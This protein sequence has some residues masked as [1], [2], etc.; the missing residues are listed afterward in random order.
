MMLTR[1][2]KLAKDFTT[3]P[4][5]QHENSEGSGGK[6]RLNFGFLSRKA[7]ELFLRNDMKYNSRY[8]LKTLAYRRSTF[9]ALLLLLPLSI[10]FSGCREGKSRQQPEDGRPLL[11]LSILPQ[12]YFAE[13]IGG[14][15]V[16][17]VVLAGPGQNPHNY[18]M[19]PRQM[20]EL[21][22][23]GAWILSGAEFEISLKPKIEKLFPDLKIVNSIEGI[24]LRSLE[25]GHVHAAHNHE[26]GEF[27]DTEIDRHTW[28]GC[29]GAI[30]IAWHIAETLCDLDSANAEVYLGNCGMLMEEIFNV[31]N[32][33]KKELKPLEGKTVFVYHPAFGYFLDEFGIRQEAVETGGKEPSMKQLGFLMEKARSENAKVIFVQAQF[34]AAAARTVAEAAN[35]ELV[36]LD[37]LAENWM[38]NILLM[39]EA[40]KKTIGKNQ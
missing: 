1:L 25:A 23:T 8:K 15:L 40:L 19:S 5:N 34:P 7:G 12:K 11:A 6:R 22:A 13:R 9:L 26:D 20:Q 2:N 35:A 28:L 4:A 27:C 29:E 21:A 3:N 14:D 39:G 17:T 31:F 30:N 33:L 24:R 36:S 16:R 18:E 10:F 37:P 32:R 38:E